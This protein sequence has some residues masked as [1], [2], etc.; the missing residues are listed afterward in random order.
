MNR[1]EINSSISRINIRGKEYVEVAARIQGFWLLYPEGSIATKLLSDDGKRCMFLAQCLDANGR[2][3]STGHAYEIQ[4]RG[5]N[6]T[7]YIENCET[8]AVGRALGI[9]GIGSTESIASAEE[10]SNAVAQQEQAPKQP[11]QRQ[12]K[13][14]PSQSNQAQA[15]KRLEAACAAYEQAHPQDDKEPGWALNGVKQ[16]PD[17]PPKSA[18][19]AERAEW[20]VMVAEE[21]ES[22]L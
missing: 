18:P 1:Q 21:F 7:S 20:F 11:Q 9:L 8:S 12:Q 2:V 17:L 6:A 3:L 10:V 19:D 22:S 5:V 15:F 16:R 14:Q 13:P 4:G